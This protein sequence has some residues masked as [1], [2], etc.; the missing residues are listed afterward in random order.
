MKQTK[1][2][3]CSNCDKEFPRLWKAKTRE[4]GAMCKDCWNGYKAGEVSI[5]NSIKKA[6]RRIKPISDK[7]AKE[8]VEYRKLRDEYLKENP[9]CEICGYHKVELHHKKPRAYHLTDVS[10]FMSV[11]RKCHTRIEN[12]DKWAR[13]NGYKL[14]HLSDNKMT[15]NK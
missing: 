6:P 14:N 2:K 15:D 4:H 9:N 8:L 1:L 5:D 12:E 3:R 13:D 11:C 10:I 7:L